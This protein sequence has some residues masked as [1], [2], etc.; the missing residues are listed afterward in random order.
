MESLAAGRMDDPLDSS[1]KIADVFR[2]RIRRLNWLRSDPSR[3]ASLK[4]YYRSHIADFISDWGATYVPFNAAKKLP[5]SIPFILDKKQ[6]EWVDFT[7]EN[8]RDGEYGGT[9]KSR[10]VGLSWLMVAFSIALCVLEENITIGWGSF[11]EIKVDRSGDMG[12]LFEKGRFFVDSLPPEFR[13][14]YDRETCSIKMIL[15][16][17]ATKGSIIGEIGDKIGRGGRTAIYF[18]DEAAHLEHDLVVDAALSKNTPCR[19]DISS[20]KGMTNSFATRM[21]DGV[22]R[23]FTYH[24]R[25][26]PRFTE[27]DYDKFRKQWGP[28]IT[29]QEL[30][31]DYLASVE[32]VIIPQ[33]HV[34]A[35]ID[36]HVKL[37]IEPSGVLSGAL[38][39]ADEGKDVNAFAARHGPLVTHCSSWRGKGSF[40]HETTDRA[41]L[42]CDT[43]QLEGFNYDADG[44]GSGV[45]SDVDRIEARR[46]AERMKKLRVLP[47][48]GSGEVFQA[49]QK[50]KGTDRT[51]KDMY[52]NLKAQSW[53]E[54]ARRAA[55]TARAV[56]EGG[57]Y[58]PDLIISLDSKI[59]ELSKLCMELSQAQWKISGNGKL[60]VDKTPDGSASPNLADA[61]VMLFAPKPRP[62]KISDAA[63]DPENW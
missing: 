40:L 57:P 28:V 26:N 56:L 6:R 47:Y 20:V 16:F 63:L 58:D 12:S 19:Q 33:A 35:M 10:D 23:K 62:M 8:W 53:G 3:N 17:P 11:S 61:I 4:Q 45:R 30:D 49:E 9:E 36:A 43:L 44:M 1:A 18:V 39:V 32:G 15:T 34:Q 14:G 7:Y 52:Q 60:M 13:S 2:S 31:I 5:V 59:P 25:E 24:W 29:A 27:A 48:R 22:S 54:L 37:R 38:D 55:E 21:H 46:K 41:Y 42:L 50:V 51:A